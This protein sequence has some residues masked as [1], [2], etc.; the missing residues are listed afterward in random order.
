[1]VYLHFHL[2]CSNYI[3]FFLPNLIPVHSKGF[4]PD[5]YGDKITIFILPIV[6]TVLLLLSYTKFFPN[7]T[8]Y[9]KS[10]FKTME[11]YRLLIFATVCLL[12][13]IE[14]FIIIFSF[15]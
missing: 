10:I 2:Y 12:F 3:L 11:Q 6:Q 14:I 4:V 13:V 9:Y 7:Y 1:M 8:M 5:A 15:L